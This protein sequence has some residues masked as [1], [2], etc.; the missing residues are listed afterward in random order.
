[1]A[2]LALLPNQA[3]LLKFSAFFRMT[4]AKLRE[5]GPRLCGPCGIGVFSATMLY[6]NVKG[7]LC[8]PAKSGMFA[9]RR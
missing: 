7:R 6:A 9:R 5:I 4:G 8:G 2:R 1:M 3:V